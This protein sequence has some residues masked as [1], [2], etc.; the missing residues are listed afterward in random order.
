MSHRLK[1][2]K[3]RGKKGLKMKKQ[4]LGLNR[5]PRPWLT[6]MRCLSKLR[7]GVL[8]LTTLLSLLQL[9]LSKLQT[10]RKRRRKLKTR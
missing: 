1:K 9:I 4:N 6:K 10:S 8:L 5:K 7:I 3:K 2:T